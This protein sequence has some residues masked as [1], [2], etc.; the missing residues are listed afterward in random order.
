MHLD[1]QLMLLC[2]PLRHLDLQHPGPPKPRLLLVAPSNAAADLLV[3]RLRKA[4]RPVSEILRINA[5]ARP[6]ED[7][8]AGVS[9]MG[10]GPK[11]GTGFRG[12]CRGKSQLRR[13]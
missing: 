6:T 12:E 5:Y 13:S 9:P 8:P 2:C 11:D 7:V 10:K 1:L 3:L 4:G